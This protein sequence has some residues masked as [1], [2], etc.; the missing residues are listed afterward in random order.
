MRILVTGS[1]GF[2]GQHAVRELSAAGH[3]IVHFREG[4]LGD[5][6]LVDLRDRAATDALV[7]AA[8][9]DAVLH[10]GGIAFVPKAWEEPHL[11]YEVNVIGTLNILDSIRRHRPGAR[12]MLASTAQVYGHGAAAAP[13]TEDA[14][15][16]PDNIY[17]VSKVAADTHCLLFAKRHRM[18]IMTARPSNHIGPGQSPDFVVA[19]FARQVADIRD[20]KQEPVMRVGNLESERDFLDVR[21]IVR[22]YRLILEKGLAGQA[23]NLGSGRFVRVRWLLDTLCRIAGVTPRIEI[24]P[25]RFRPVEV[26]PPLDVSRITLET[27]WTPLI[28]IEDTLADVLKDAR[29]NTA[30]V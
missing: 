15:L 9:P 19:S 28:R 18:N 8:R 26:Q 2:V 3:E 16:R 13:L 6:P 17:A 20:G 30:A 12:F 22:A 21:D 29:A 10:L 1:S 11:C 7:R 27:G 14:P 23:Y 5:T 25:S 24:D 4:G